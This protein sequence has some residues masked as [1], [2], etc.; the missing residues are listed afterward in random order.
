MSANGSKFPYSLLA[1]HSSITMEV[2]EVFSG[3]E[4]GWLEIYQD[5]HW[6]IYPKR[7]LRAGNE[8]T[9]SQECFS[10]YNPL[11]T[12][13]TINLSLHHCECARR[14]ELTHAFWAYTP[15]P[16]AADG[17]E[18]SIIFLPCVLGAQGHLKK[19]YTPT[20]R[21]WVTFLT[22]SFFTKCSTTSQD[23]V[24]WVFQL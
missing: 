10:L 19:L 15:G 22:C 6:Q 3:S 18:S 9:S 4:D 21:T 2:G 16:P 23:L 14:W 8:N 13:F 1:C 20:C 5:L 24:I 17:C 11:S 12:H 7:I